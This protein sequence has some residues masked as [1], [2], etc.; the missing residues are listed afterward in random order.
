[1]T[2]GSESPIVVL[3]SRLIA[4][5]IQVFGLYTILHGH[6]GPG[7]GFQGG[8]MLAASVLL[9]RLCIRN[10]A[11]QMLFKH[12]MGTPAG[13]AGALVFVGVGIVT[14]LA[15]GSFLDYSTLPFGE[16]SPAR[17][18]SMG[19]LIVEV[20]IGVAVMSTLISIFDSLLGDEQNG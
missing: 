11:D 9:V 1:M 20:G 6:Y 10:E 7:G 14:I 12:T 3:V 8:A 19:I 2:A 4:P 16:M 13:I 17:L 5:L 15:G 18:R